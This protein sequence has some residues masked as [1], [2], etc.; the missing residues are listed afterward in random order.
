MDIKDNQ[1]I[2]LLLQQYSNLK[3]EQRSN[4]QL[5]FISILISSLSFTMLFIVGILSHSYIILIFSPT[6][7]LFFGLL[8][9]STLGS[10]TITAVGLLETEDRINEIVGD[11]LLKW[12]STGGIFFTLGDDI[13]VKKIGRYINKFSFTALICIIVPLFFGLGLGLYWFISENSNLVS[14][15]LAGTIIVVYAGISVY[16]LKLGVGLFYKKDWEKI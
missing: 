12:E 4:W 10:L 14:Y 11:Q 16:S 2:T 3:S 9:M 13:V 15:V 6:I 1:K 8:S 7:A 5:L